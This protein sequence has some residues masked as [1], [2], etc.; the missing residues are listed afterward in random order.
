LAGISLPSKS[1]QLFCLR[2]NTFAGF[3]QSL[4]TKTN[5]SDTAPPFK[6]RLRYMLT[7][8]AIIDLL[9]IIPFYLTIFF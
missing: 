3:G 5:P 6:G 8:M 7:P 2:L 1:S 9:A 4:I